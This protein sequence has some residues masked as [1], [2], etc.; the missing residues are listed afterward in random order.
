MPGA[1]A[2]APA[3]AGPR[4]RS[5]ARGVHG[6]G[7]RDGVRGVR[8]RGWAGD[9]VPRPDGAARGSGVVVWHD[10]TGG[11]GGGPEVSAAGG[12][13]T[14]APGSGSG[15]LDGGAET[16]MGEFPVGLDFAW[17]ACDAAGHVAVFTNAGTGP[18]PAAVLAERPAADR[19]C[20]LVRDVPRVG[21]ETVAG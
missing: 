9:R 19:S 10:W 18:I 8:P 20:T 11:S 2:G 1:A 6:G 16:R 3:A 7:R 14:D 13:P 17:L 15:P 12:R 21:C 4:V 5:H